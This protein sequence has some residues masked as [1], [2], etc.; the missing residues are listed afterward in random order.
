MENTLR[1][2]LSDLAFAKALIPLDR[3][4]QDESGA[5]LLCVSGMLLPD[6]AVVHVSVTGV[7]DC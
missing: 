2:E 1:L 4:I 6:E 3:E 5:Q 7:R